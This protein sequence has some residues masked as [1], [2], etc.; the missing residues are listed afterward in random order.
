MSNDSG[1]RRPLN[2]RSSWWAGAILKLLLRTGLTPNQ[3][4]VAGVVAAGVGAYGF[5][6][7]QGRHPAWLLLA[8]LGIQ[9]RL[10]CNLLDGMLAVEGGRISKV[11]ELYNEVPDR[12][13]DVVIILG[14]GYAYRDVVLCGSCDTVTIA[15]CAALGAVLTAYVRQVGAAVG[16]GHQF[17]GPM[18]KPHRM[19][20]LSVCCI[21]EIA[22]GSNVAP[23]VLIPAGLALIALGCVVTIFRRLARIVQFLEARP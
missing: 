11:G 19:A 4:S 20:L 21:G 14:A 9:L 6:L 13:S 5:F 7:G 18:A 10:L 2:S 22:L 17:L 3:V 1:A 15:W 16:A 12:V 23:T 8:I